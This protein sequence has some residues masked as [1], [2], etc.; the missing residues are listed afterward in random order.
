MKRYR[1]YKLT[2]KS[3]VV[4]EHDDLLSTQKAKKKMKC[5]NQEITMKT[6]RMALMIVMLAAT[7]SCGGCWNKA[8]VNTAQTDQPVPEPINLLLPKSV[9]IH[10][11][12]GTRSFDEAGGIR[13]IDVRIEAVDH[14]GDP[15]KAFGQMRFELFRFK[16]NSTDPKGKRIA[17]WEESTI[18]P[19][20]NLV[21]W[22]KITRTYEFKLQWDS[23]IPVGRKFVLQAVFT[24]PFT[25]RMFAERVFISGQ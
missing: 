17:V 6:S 10:P 1:L 24:S 14:Y 5:K 25:E 3:A 12:T 8:D 4:S 23:P 21:H 18:A 22:D 13:G 11:F 2:Q 7:V 9:R 16:P 19:K 20:K 15:T